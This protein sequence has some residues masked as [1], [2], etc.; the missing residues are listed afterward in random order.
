MHESTNA[1]RTTTSVLSNGTR[2]LCVHA[3]TRVLRPFALAGGP[4][5]WIG[6]AVVETVAS[7][8]RVRKWI[9]EL[10]KRRR[11]PDMG[12][13]YIE[14]IGSSDADGTFDVA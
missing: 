5:G 6:T 11:P 12:T 10:R 13:W 8:D 14:S 4:D 3:P 1:L 2:G 9:W 7:D